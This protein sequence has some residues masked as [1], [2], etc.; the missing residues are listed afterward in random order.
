FTT[1]NNS[2]F[3]YVWPTEVKSDL[4]IAIA[5]DALEPSP[6]PGGIVELIRISTSRYGTF[7]CFIV[8]FIV[9]TIPD[10]AFGASS[11]E[12]WNKS[13]SIYTGPLLYFVTAFTPIS[14]KGTEIAGCPSTTACSPTKINLLWAAP[15]AFFSDK[16]IFSTLISHSLPLTFLRNRHGFVLLLLTFEQF[17]LL[18]HYLHRP[19]QP[20]TAHEVPYDLFV[21]HLLQVLL[22]HLNFAPI[23]Q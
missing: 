7:N 6:L 14:G 23:Q 20:Q 19:Q 18:D 22:K 21:C 15:T 4:T 12:P 10:N 8:C 17:L 13:L 11:A 3:V 16:D 9:C 5:T 2:S 1:A